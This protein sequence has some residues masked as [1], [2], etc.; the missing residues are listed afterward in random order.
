VSATIDPQ[1]Q[2]GLQVTPDAADEG[3]ASDAI[4]LVRRVYAAFERGDGAAIFAL[5]HPEG[6]IYQSSRLPWGG[7]YRGHAGLGAFLAALTG[8]VESRVVAQRYVADLDGHVVAAGQTRG[9]VLATGREFAVD[10]VHVWTIEDGAVRRFESYVD[11]SPMRAAL[12]L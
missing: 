7:N 10:E 3:A 9:R 2:T 5:F 4:G 6:E 8:A 12:G 1:V 11:G